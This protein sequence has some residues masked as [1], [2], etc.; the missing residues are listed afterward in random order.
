MLGASQTELFTQLEY[1]DVLISAIEQT[2]A[3]EAGDAAAAA[4]QQQQQA[5][6][7]KPT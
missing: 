4:E 5:A 7:D 3:E 1:P 6:A 2:E